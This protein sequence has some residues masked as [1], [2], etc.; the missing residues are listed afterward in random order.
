MA[1]G[2]SVDQRDPMTGRVTTQ[3]IHP[4]VGI[5]VA[6][7]ATA[8]AA[9]LA[10]GES[11]FGSAAVALIAFIGLMLGKTDL[12]GQAL[13]SG[14]GLLA[15]QYESGFVLTAILLIVGAAIAGAQYWN[16]KNSTAP[17]H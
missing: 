17:A 8:V 7:V 14:S 3:K 13:R 4:V 2:T 15:I 10:L 11:S 6:L 12:D 1:I 9:L 16:R 5:T